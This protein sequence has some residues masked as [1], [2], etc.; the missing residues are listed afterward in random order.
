MAGR[1]ADGHGDAERRE[2][3]LE[4]RARAVAASSTPPNVTADSEPITMP[5]S[6]ANRPES[7]SVPEHPVD[8]IGLLGDLF[9]EEERAGVVEFPRRA[10]GGGEERETPSDERSR[11]RN[12]HED[13]T[14]R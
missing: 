2:P 1:Q 5:D 13:A 7:I 10:D 12:R 14:G 8:A 6:L 11:R 3:G 9:E 4:D